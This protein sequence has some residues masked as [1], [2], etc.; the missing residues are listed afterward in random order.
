MRIA[1]LLL[2]TAALAAPAAGAWTVNASAY[3]PNDAGPRTADGSPF[4]WSSNVVAHR[5][6]PLGTRVAVT[7]RGRTSITVV[8]DRGPYIAGRDLDLGPVVWRHLGGGITSPYQWG[9]RPVQLT[10]LPAE[11]VRSV[12]TARQTGTGTGAQRQ[13]VSREQ[14]ANRMRQRAVVLTRRYGVF[15]WPEY[16]AKMTG[17]VAGWV[18][19]HGSQLASRSTCGPAAD[20][21]V[22]FGCLTT[23]SDGQR[24]RTVVRVLEDGSPEVLSRKVLRRGR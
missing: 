1:L 6:L 3:S 8:R 24:V 18:L 20:S 22:R 17:L 7:Y 10:V 12:L 9:T 4:T 14:W 21:T 13:R 23:R 2:I 11:P 15:P 16:D 19:A 5:T